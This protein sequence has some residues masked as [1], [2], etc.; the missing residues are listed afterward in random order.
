[1]VLD[2]RWRWKGV[3]CRW[4]VEMEGG[5]VFAQVLA[6]KIFSLAIKWDE[7]NLE[8]IDG[9]ERPSSALD[10]HQRIVCGRLQ[11]LLKDA[12]DS[13]DEYACGYGLMLHGGPHKPAAYYTIRL[14]IDL[15]CVNGVGWQILRARLV[16]WRNQPVEWLP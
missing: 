8:L 12:L 2:G 9:L 13:P 14:S 11:Q 15:R 5:W 1:M 3:G 10:S 7:L 6:T 4:S 16:P